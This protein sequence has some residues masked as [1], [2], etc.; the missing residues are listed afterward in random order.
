MPIIGPIDPGALVG[1]IK[2]TAVSLT[3]RLR[4]DH[5]AI[6]RR[7]VRFSNH[8]MGKLYLYQAVAPSR[9]SKRSYDDAQ[10]GRAAAFIETAFPGVFDDESGKPQPE[11]ANTE[12]TRFQ[13]NDADEYPDQYVFVHPTGLIEVQW[14]L[15]EKAGSDGN[16][17]L[18]ATEIA[19][20]VM[21][22]ARAIGTEAYAELSNLGSRRGDGG[23][24]G[25]TGIWT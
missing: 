12:W 1:S 19:T 11:G 14:A 17:V 4:P 16:V 8:A 22:L 3:S 24:P 5:Q 9:W 6:Q 10:V 20:L 21:C 18:D 25:S 13:V 7:N 15:A 2:R 23:S